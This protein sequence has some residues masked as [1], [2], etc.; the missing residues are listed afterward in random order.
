MP[1]LITFCGY[2][3]DLCPAYEKNHMKYPDKKKICA[4]WNKYFDLTVTPDKITCVGCRNEGYHPDSKCPVRSCA[5]QRKVRY[6]VDC[7]DFNTCKTIIKRTE[8]LEPVK[9]K[10]GGRIPPADY[11]LFFAPYESKRHFKKLNKK[12]WKS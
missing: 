4:G 7:S 6:C 3:C 9:W 10:F 1:A 2:R 8:V 11:N 12:S 5:Q